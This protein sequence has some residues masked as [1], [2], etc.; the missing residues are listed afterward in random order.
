MKKILIGLLLA[1]SLQALA[2]DGNYDFLPS[3]CSLTRKDAF[4]LTQAV[5]NQRAV[6]AENFKDQNLSKD[7]IRNMNADQIFKTH[8]EYSNLEFRVHQAAQ[9]F[10]HYIQVQC[11]RLPAWK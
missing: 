7:K 9:E 4:E 5:M 6:I 3:D 11:K 10:A 8:T 2:K 1:T